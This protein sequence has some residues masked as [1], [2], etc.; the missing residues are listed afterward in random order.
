MRGFLRM[1]LGDFGAKKLA[2]V[3]SG[4]RALFLALWTVFGT[5]AEV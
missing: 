5:G 4:M 3:D 2:F 1:C